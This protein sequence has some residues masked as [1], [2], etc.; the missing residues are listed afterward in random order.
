MCEWQI[1]A[2][3]GDGCDFGAGGGDIY[4]HEYLGRVPAT[5]TTVV[6][7]NSPV[8]CQHAFTAI[9][10][11]ARLVWFGAE[12]GFLS[13]GTWEKD[14]VSSQGLVANHAYYDWPSGYHPSLT[15]QRQEYL[16]DGGI[17]SCIATVFS[18]SPITYRHVYSWQYIDVLD[19]QTRIP[20]ADF[21]SGPGSGGASP[22]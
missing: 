2:Y 9:N 5:G 3:P 1:I 14:V 7:D 6:Y 20:P 18:T 4:V 12:D 17:A 19:R 22:M 16:I 8:P 11:V 15:N 21:G 10:V 13:S